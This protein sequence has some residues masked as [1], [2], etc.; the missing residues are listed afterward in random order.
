MKRNLTGGAC[1][2]F[3][4]FSLVLAL[5]AGAQ[6][7]PTELNVAVI[8][9]EGAVN[10]ARQRA[11]QDPAIRVEDENRKPVVA[12]TVVFTLPTEGAT[13]EFGNGSK[14]V[15]VTTNSQGEAAAPGLKVNQVEGKLPIHVSVSYRGLSARTNI[16]QFIEASAGA[17]SSKGGGHSSGK[18]IAILAV[19]GAAAAGGAA[20]ALKKS[21]SAAVVPSVPAIVPIG[22]TPGTGTIVGNH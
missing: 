14:S 10:N 9:G 17:S 21:P 12:A 7:L 15:T 8:G 13:G 1:S 6:T 5:S 19:V 3:L 20:F 2:R 11:S 16:V 4:V 18:I 22:I